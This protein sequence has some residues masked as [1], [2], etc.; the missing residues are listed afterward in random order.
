VSATTLVA[1]Q[2]E[3]PLSPRWRGRVGMWCLIAAESAIFCIFVVAYL[4]YAGK[5]LSGPTPAEVLEVPVIASIGLF[6]SS[7]TIWLAERALDAGRIRQFGLFWL[8][9]I[10]LGAGFLLATD[11]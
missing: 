1:P 9:T 5:S 10:L 7:L 6:A 2:I 4:Y 3:L 8:V 11:L